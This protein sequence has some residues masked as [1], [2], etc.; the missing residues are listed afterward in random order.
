MILVDGQPSEYVDARD[1]GLAYGDGLFETLACVDGRP[2]AFDAHFARLRR[3]ATWLGLN[4]PSPALLASEIAQCCDGRERA[5][6]KIVLTRGSGGR[7]YRPLADGTTRRIV[8]TYEWPTLP[9][10]EERLRAWVCHHRLGHNP[11]TAGHKHLNRLDQVMASREWPGP[12]YFEGLMR[13]QHDDFVE[14]TRSNLFVVSGKRLLTPA[15]DGGGIA[16][17]VRAEVLAQAATIGL[18]CEE[19]TVN[20]AHLDRADEVFLTGSVIGVR[21]L[22]RIDGVRTW[23]FAQDTVSRALRL[24]LQRQAIVA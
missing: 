7:G 8:S 19:T 14:G 20:S 17:I 15:L 24:A 18:V 12:H 13:D 6:A 2:L 21:A 9:A 11:L 5:V 3:S 4:V 16:G 1:R 22:G 23:H 10:A